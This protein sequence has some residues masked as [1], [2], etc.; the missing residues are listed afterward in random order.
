MSSTIS[1]VVAANLE[2]VM[3]EQKISQYA[4]S[5]RSGVP[6]ATVSRILRRIH[7]P[8]L[9]V[10]EALANGL[11]V[12]LTPL[13]TSEFDHSKLPKAET[14]ERPQLLGRQLSRLVQDFMLSDMEKRQRILQIA[15]ECA[16]SSKNGA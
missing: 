8:G 6:Q 14:P 11:G 3:S 13:I 2:A 1:E 15:Q 10:L 16:D 4:L 9:E 12:P 7:T 5:K